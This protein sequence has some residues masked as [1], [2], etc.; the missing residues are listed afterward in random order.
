MKLYIVLLALGL[1]MVGGGLWF[2][3]K[4]MNAGTIEI[5]IS[6]SPGNYLTNSQNVSS[7][8]LLKDIKIETSVS[9]R[10]YGYPYFY[11]GESSWYQHPVKIGELI[12]TV[13]GNIQ[14]N[15]AQNKEIAMYAEGYD[16]T[17]KQ[18]VWTLDSAHI[19]GQIRLH[20]ENGEEGKFTL[21]LNYSEDIKALHIFANNYPMTPL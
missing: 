8:V 2:L 14:N 21:H 3:F 15:H 10:Q 6:T 18:V 9:D 20:L 1:V 11:A 7:E 16:A 4:P 19:A 13:S 5:A 17:G 12:L